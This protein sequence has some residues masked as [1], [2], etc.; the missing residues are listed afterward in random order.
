MFILIWSKAIC[1]ERLLGGGI[2]IIPQNIKPK[3]QCSIFPVSSLNESRF[4]KDYTELLKKL[5]FP[6]RPVKCFTLSLL[7][8]VRAG[9]ILW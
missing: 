5:L 1:Y 3:N 6:Y 9:K 8:E 7:I 4:K 2:S